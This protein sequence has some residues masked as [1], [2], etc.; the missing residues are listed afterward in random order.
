MNGELTAVN[1]PCILPHSENVRNSRAGVN[2]V[3]VFHPEVST[4]NQF[5][6]AHCDFWRRR[7]CFS[8]VD[9]AAAVDF[10]DT[11][12][13]HGLHYGIVSFCPLRPSSAESLCRCCDQR[14]RQNC[15]ECGGTHTVFPIHAKFLL[16]KFLG[17]RSIYYPT[18]T[19]ISQFV[20]D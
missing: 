11:G 6:A 4:S 14:K 3:A 18:Y 7:L 10:A 19:P 2:I 8:V 20:S 13:G 1:I 12:A 16:S 9:D 15:R 17:F 5:R